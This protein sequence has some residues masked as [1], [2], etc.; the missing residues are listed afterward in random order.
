MAKNAK[1]NEYL[2]LTVHLPIVDILRDTDMYLY[3]KGTKG[4]A[5]FLTYLCR[6]TNSR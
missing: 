2:T 6:T 1:Q 3:C 5:L 4:N